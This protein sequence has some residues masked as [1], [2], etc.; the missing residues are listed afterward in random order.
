MA[1][2]PYRP[3]GTNTSFVIN[4]RATSSLSTPSRNHGIVA[5]VP[6]R[7]NFNFPQYENILDK[8]RIHL[9]IWTIHK[10]VS[11]V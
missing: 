11:G 2:F 1:G 8:L 10:N 6:D 9:Y 5:G 7:N 4:S 3:L